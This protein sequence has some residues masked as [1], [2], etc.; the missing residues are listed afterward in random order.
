M[1]SSVAGPL[2][3]AVVVR[4]YHLSPPPTQAGRHHPGSPAPPSLQVQVLLRRSA[5][6]LVLEPAV[7]CTQSTIGKMSRMRTE[8]MTRMTEISILAAGA[9]APDVRATAPGVARRQQVDVYG[10]GAPPTT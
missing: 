2:M 9:P 5:L 10:V 6:A 4:H 3:V 8:I 7:H 1:A